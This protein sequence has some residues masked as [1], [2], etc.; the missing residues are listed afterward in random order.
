KQYIPLSFIA[1]FTNLQETM[2]S[3]EFTK[4]F[5]DFEKLQ[6]VTFSQL[7][8]LKFPYEV[9]K[10]KL[11]NNF[12]EVNGKTLREFYICRDVISPT[13]R[14]LYM[15]RDVISPNL[16][17]FTKFCPNLRRLSIS[18]ENN[19]LETLK[20]VF[21]NCQFLESMI[22]WYKGEFMNEREILEVVVKYSLKSFHEFGFSCLDHLS[23]DCIVL[24]PE[25]LESILVS[26]SNRIPLKPLSL[27]TEKYSSL[28]EKEN[29]KIIKKYIDLGVIKKYESIDL[30]KKLYSMIS[31]ISDINYVK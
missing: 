22:I 10:L 2:L 11:L 26:W 18:F 24:L 4:F 3:F 19:K 13:L 6:Y 8:I 31:E 7:Q 23:I 29:T 30:W 21:N 15:C 17:S 5:E 28:D 14:E 12:L 16:V 9:P 1:S 20:T 25:E 27:F